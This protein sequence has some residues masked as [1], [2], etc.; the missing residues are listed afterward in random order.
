MLVYFT[1]PTKRPG[2][3]Q[4]QLTIKSR[5]GGQLNQSV[6]T[7]LR[8]FVNLR[9]ATFQFLENETLRRFTFD[10]WYD[11]VRSYEVVLQDH[12]S[13]YYCICCTMVIPT[14]SE[15]NSASQYLKHF[16]TSSA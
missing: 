1:W 15:K 4:S 2:G 12:C 13:M 10:H 9:Q 5:P 14:H 11:F 7:I 16:N 6:E 3:H 8:T